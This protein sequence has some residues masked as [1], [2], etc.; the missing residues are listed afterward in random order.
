M[1]PTGTVRDFRD[2]QQLRLIVGNAGAVNLVCGGKDLG[3]AGGA[4]KVRRFT[5]NASGIVAG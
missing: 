1:L 3:P 5:C 2:P 4:G